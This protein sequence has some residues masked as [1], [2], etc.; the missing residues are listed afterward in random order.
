MISCVTTETVRVSEAAKYFDVDR[1]HIIHYVDDSNSKNWFYQSFYDQTVSLIK[2]S[3]PDVQICEHNS[4]V[5]YFDNMLREVES[6]VELENLSQVQPVIYVNISAGSPEY[7][8]AATII[9]MMHENTEPVSVGAGEYLHQDADDLRSIYYDGSTPVGLIKTIREPHIVQQFNISA[10]NRRLV[11]G[12][13]I[14]DR[15]IKDGLP[16]TSK[17]MVAEF[18]ES[19]IWERS[20]EANDQVYYNRDFIDKWIASKWVKRDPE[21]H[22]KLIITEFGHFVIK[23]FYL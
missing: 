12:L 10:P 14:L 16:L 19:G 15:H 5:F 20:S 22:K 13:R 8:S 1:I 9:S 21:M 7:I 17:A 3:L 4:K 6:I 2:E 23:T 11:I 18:K